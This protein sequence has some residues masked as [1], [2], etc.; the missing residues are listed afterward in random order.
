[1][2]L[3]TNIWKCNGDKWNWWLYRLYHLKS[4]AI[5][6]DWNSHEKTQQV[7]KVNGKILN[8]RV[9]V[10]WVIL[11]RIIDITLIVLKVIV[12]RLNALPNC[13]IKCV[14]LK[15]FFIAYL[16]WSISSFK[17]INYS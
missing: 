9:L 3:W 13:Q 10:G 14:W 12:I 15:Q 2:K 7:I 5:V 1:M 17:I 4:C 11:Q 6:I 8:F 16:F